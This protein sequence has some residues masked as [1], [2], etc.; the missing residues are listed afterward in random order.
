VQAARADVS[1]ASFFILNTLLYVLMVVLFLNSKSKFDLQKA[2]S[3]WEVK[4]S[5]RFTNVDNFYDGVLW[6]MEF[7]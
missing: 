5:N 7:I 6:I 3:C 2:F 4:Q 1:V